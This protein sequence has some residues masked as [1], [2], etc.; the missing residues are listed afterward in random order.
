MVQYLE[1]LAAT[2]PAPGALGGQGFV[3]ARMVR[4]PGVADCLRRVPYGH[5]TT[6]PPR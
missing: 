5:E 3:A 6:V 4:P 1:F 2:A